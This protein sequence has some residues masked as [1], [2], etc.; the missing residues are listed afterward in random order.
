M[1]YAALA[2]EKCSEDGLLRSGQSKYSLVRLRPGLLR[3]LRDFRTAPRN[4][5]Q[6]V[7]INDELPSVWSK[8]LAHWMMQKFL[9]TSFPQPTGFEIR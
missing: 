5:P 9:R 1:A 6:F 4:R 2:L 8:Q 7:C 3:N